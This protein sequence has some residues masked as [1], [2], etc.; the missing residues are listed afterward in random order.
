MH[1]DPS[2]TKKT[3]KPCKLSFSCLSPTHPI[4]HSSHFS[5]TALSD[6][7]FYH[8][9]SKTLV[10]G[11]L[12]YNLPNTESMPEYRA[13]L[14]KSLSPGGLAHTKLISGAAK[15]RTS[16]QTDVKTVAALDFD[17]I[18]PLHGVSIFIQYCIDI[19]DVDSVGRTLSK[20]VDWKNGGSHMRRLNC[21]N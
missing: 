3:S 7:A 20:R 11:D 15:D 17:R 4:G 21:S 19:H 9:K 18:I 8:A 5:G 16:V 1:P 10:V 14:W 12:I 6:T 13:S 2:A